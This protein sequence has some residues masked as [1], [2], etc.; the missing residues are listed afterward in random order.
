[1]FQNQNQPSDNNPNIQGNQSKIKTCPYCN[2]DDF[3]V[4]SDLKA[5]TGFVECQSCG[6]TGPEVELGAEI[7]AWNC[8][9]GRDTLVRVICVA[10]KGFIF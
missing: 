7:A 3:L 5:G 2:S 8:R 6:A 10:P 9:E 4:I 1:M